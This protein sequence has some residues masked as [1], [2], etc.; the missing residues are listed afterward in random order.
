ME[1]SKTAIPIPR[2]PA[3]LSDNPAVLLHSGR[4]GN[5]GVCEQEAVW[6]T[7][8]GSRSHRAVPVV[9]SHAT[10]LSGL[11]RLVSHLTPPGE[12]GAKRL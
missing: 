10:N 2:W 12:L 6:V 3:S 8:P 11:L 1:G 4:K 9:A 7:P 5:L